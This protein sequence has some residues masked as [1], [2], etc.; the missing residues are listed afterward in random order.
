MLSKLFLNIPSH[1]FVCCG[2]CYEN[3]IF[4]ENLGPGHLG[5]GGYGLLSILVVSVLRH[6]FVPRKSAFLNAVSL[7]VVQISVICGPPCRQWRIGGGS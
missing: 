7:T 3:F 4:V 2:R 6:R 5:G 1:Y